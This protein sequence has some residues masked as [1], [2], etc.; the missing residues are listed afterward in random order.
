M[1]V[2]LLPENRDVSNFENIPIGGEHPRFKN[3]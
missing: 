1:F 3:R 2:T